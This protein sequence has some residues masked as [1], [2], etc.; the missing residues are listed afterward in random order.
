MCSNLL[1]VPNN[2]AVKETHSALLTVVHPTCLATELPVVVHPL[3]STDLMFLKTVFGK[4]YQEV[5]RSLSPSDPLL[6]Q[7]VRGWGDCGRT[8]KFSQLLRLYSVL[9]RFARGLAILTSSL[10]A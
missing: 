5:G 2:L 10:F 4:C 7:A 3:S 8:H 6:S 1:K 9:S